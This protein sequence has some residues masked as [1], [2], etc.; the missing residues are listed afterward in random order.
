[1]RSR[2]A[3]ASVRTSRPSTHAEPS[4]SGNNP[5]SILMTVVLPLPL[6]PRKPKISPFSTRKLTSLTA[7]KSPKRRTRCSAAMEAPSGGWLAGGMSLTCGLQF[8]IGSHAAADAAGGVIDA[9]FYAD[10]LVDASAA[11]LHV[12]RKKF[13]LLINLLDDAVEN[14]L[15][16]RIDAHF[17]LLAQTHAANFGFG[18][19]NADV[20]LITLEERGY[21]NI[22]GDEIAGANVQHFDGGRGR[23]DNLRFASA[24]FVVV[25][26]GLSQLDVF[27]TVAAF[28][29][30]LHRLH[31][32]I[33]R[34]HGGNFF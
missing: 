3:S 29:F 28:H 4:V 12:A 13:G 25:I 34:F 9:N 2:T 7:V 18:N 19:V 11:G 30:F 22:G 16:K 17:G 21:R 27:G 15:G 33:A 10:Y 8:H 20:D 23:G 26:G 14:G 1:M 32:A 5:V 6:G 31:L 24:G